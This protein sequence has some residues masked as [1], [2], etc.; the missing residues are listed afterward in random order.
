MIYEQFTDEELSLPKG[1]TGW[2]EKD[3]MTDKT[4]SW[5]QLSLFTDEALGIKSTPKVIGL[6]GYAQS[7]K[8]TVADYLVKTHGYTRIAFADAIRD[9]VYALN[10]LIKLNKDSSTI[11]LVDLVNSLGW[12]KA[13]QEPNVREWLQNVGVFAREILD[14]QVWV[15]SAFRKVDR[16]AKTVITDV[17]FENEAIAVKALFGQLWKVKRNGVGPV[18]NH[19]S[20]TELEDYKPDQILKND[21]S[22]EDLHKLIDS[23][24]LINNAITE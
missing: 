22:I 24:L 23:R 9:F 20:E 14:P 11:F 3:V 15:V 16:D 4:K 8:D 13:K 1:P 12:E 21:G 17:R 10:P 5:T 6:I 7:G 18:N 19:I 2:T